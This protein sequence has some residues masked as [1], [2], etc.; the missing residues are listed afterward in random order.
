VKEEIA[1]NFP[2]KTRLCFSIFVKKSPAEAGLH[3]H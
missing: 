1:I 3:A 2:E